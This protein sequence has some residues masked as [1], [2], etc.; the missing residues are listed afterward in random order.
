MAEFYTDTAKTTGVGVPAA[1]VMPRK[2]HK[3]KSLKIDKEKVVGDFLKCIDEDLT[4]RQDRINRRMDRYAKYRGVVVEKFDPWEGCSNV[5]LNMLLADSLRMKAT[6]ENAVKSMRPMMSARAFQRRNQLKEDR[7]DKLIDYQLFTENKGEAKLDDYVSNFV[8]DEAAFSFTHWVRENQ[9]IREIRILPG[10]D[11]AIDHMAQLLG[12]RLPTIFPKMTNATVKDK[13]G[14]KWEVDYID[15]QNEPITASVEFYDLDDGKL[16][17]GLTYTAR[18]FDGP[19]FEAL[20]YEDVL[21]PARSANTQPPS[22]SNPLGAQYI[23]RFCKVSLDTIRRRM[24]DGTY[25]LLKKDDWSAVENSTSST[26]SGA[27]EEQ[28][29]RL[30]DQLEGTQTSFSP[31]TN[32]DSPATNTDRQMVEIYGRWDID[33]DGLE[34]DVIFWILRKERLLCKAAMLTEIYPGVPVMRPIGSTSFIPTPNR[35]DGMGLLELLETIQD[36]MKVSFDQHFDWGSLTNMPFGAYRANSGMK[37][38]TIRIEPGVMIPLD[39][40]QQDLNFPQFSQRGETFNLNTIAVLQQFRERLSMMSD[41]QFGRVPQGKAS[42]L[43]TMGTTNALLGQG[44]VQSERLL[45]RL[46]YGLS[47]VYQ[48]FHRL[49]RRYL[50]EKK[51]IRI[52]GMAEKGEETYMDVAGEDINAEVDFDFK[53]TMLNTNKQTIMQSLDHI[54][55]LIVSPLAMQAGIVTP[56]QIYNLF[57]D[58]IK[59]ADADPDRYLVRPP[60]QAMGPK[61]L[62][63]E[64]MSAIISRQ[65]PVGTPLESAQEHLQ[66]MLEF[67]KEPVFLQLDNVQKQFYRQWV[68]TIA[69]QVQAEQKQ[70]QMMAAAQQFQQAQQN[71]NGGGTPTTMNPDTGAGQPAQ[72]GQL[73]DKSLGMQ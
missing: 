25:D 33:G 32:T 1:P 38:E 51:E 44:D 17:A 46:F 13:D 37:A 64:A 55:S 19:C 29:K 73:A 42:A 31:A 54:A 6:M 21:Y 24:N 57:R 7:I 66:K 39:D 61:I 49:N 2:P 60:E 72:E 20:D 11:P 67:S 58:E 71:Q 35:I 15:E 3:K 41:I 30:K 40:P 18:T 14:W 43:R 22:A 48:M 27:P 5:P 26:A 23:A 10:L 65:M 34:E 62:A 47:Q 36:M 50:P 69:A 70:Q 28:P 63:E 4:A 56:S 68:Q 59:A 8:D 53:A 12:D 52:S 9:T 16:E 45:R